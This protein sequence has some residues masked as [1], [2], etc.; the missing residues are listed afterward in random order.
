[1][2]ALS[3]GESLQRPGKTMPDLKQYEMGFWK[4]KKK[5]KH[6]FMDWRKSSSGGAFLGVERTIYM[7]LNF[8][9]IQL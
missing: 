7:Q 2:A 8:G 6:K 1:M 3:Q 9:L 5:V 4:K